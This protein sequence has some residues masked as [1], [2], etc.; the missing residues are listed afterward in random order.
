MTSGAGRSSRAVLRTYVTRGHGGD[1]L[2]MTGGA[3]RSSRTVLRQ[4]VT[5]ARRLSYERTG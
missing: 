4:L 5:R 3:G 2:P 1:V